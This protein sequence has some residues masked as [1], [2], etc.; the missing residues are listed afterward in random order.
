MPKNQRPLRILESDSNRK[1]DLFGRLVEDLFATFGYQSFR[2]NIHKSGREIDVEAQHR[3][4][5]RRLIAECK[6]TEAP[7][8]GDDLNKFFGAV[9]VE[10]RKL[11][12]GMQMSAYFVSLSGFSETAIEQEKEAG[13]RRFVR[14]DGAQVVEELSKGHI[15]VTEAKALELASRSVARTAPDLISEERCH[16]LAHELGWIWA[17]YF[18][19]NKQRTHFVLVHADGQILS[20]KLAAEVTRA[21]KSVGGE[22]GTLAYIKPE[23]V[24]AADDEKLKSA[25][26]KYL[27]YIE[28]ECGEIQLEGLPADQEVGSRRLRLENI[29]VPL[30]VTVVGPEALGPQQ[31]EKP[32]PAR[33]RRRRAAAPPASIAKRREPIGRILAKAQ[34]LAVLG[35]PGGGKSTLLKRLAIAYAFPER[36]KLIHDQL[37]E[38]DWLPLFIRCRQLENL[39]RSPITE[40][41][42]DVRKRAEIG[43]DLAD[44]FGALVTASLHSGGAL[45]LVDGLDEISDEGDRLA[46]VQQLRTF[47]AVYPTVAVVMTCREAGF[48]NIAGAMTGHCTHLRLA[49]FNNTDIRRLTVAWH[50]EVVGDTAQN[51]A[52]AGKLADTICSTDRVRRL[53]QNPLL[54]TALLLVK[55]WV[56][57]LPTKR[58]VLYGKAVEVLLMTWN[59]E[60]HDPIDIEEALPQLEFV[61]YAMMQEG[62]Q[63]VSFPRLRDILAS[64]RAQMPEL[65]AYTKVT[66]QEFIKRVELRSSLLVLTGYEVEHGSLQAMYEFR[67]LTFQEYLTARAIV[68]GH[69][70]G[71]Q[72]PDTMLEILKPHL[73]DENWEEVVLLSAVMAGRKVQPLVKYLI[74]QVQQPTLND[75]GSNERD[76]SPVNLLASCVVDEIQVPPDLLREALR[77]IARRN[78]YEG[79]PLRIFRGKYGNLFEDVCLHELQTSDS[80]LLS[81]GGTIGALAV[82]R[83]GWPSCEFGAILNGLGALLDDPSDLRRTEGLLATMQLAWEVQ[84]QANRRKDLSPELIQALPDLLPRITPF[85]RSHEQHL[86]LGAMWAFVWLVRAKKQ[87]GEAGLATLDDLLA[88]WAEWKLADLSYLAAWSISS[89]PVGERGSPHPSTPREELV[90]FVRSR[91]D[92]AHSD[93]AWPIHAELKAALWVAYHVRGPWPDEELA[94]LIAA[95]FDPGDGTRDQLLQGLGK[96]GLAALEELHRAER[97]RLVKTT[98]T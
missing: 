89:L 8:G 70:P 82:D 35:L 71:R 40:I 15:I 1:G 12:E 64:A 80:D 60:G 14:L 50:K 19:L 16:L 59:V 38:R 96:P 54:L 27:S 88:A 25:M 31:P 30:H 11:P 53:A 33:L 56:G 92:S 18:G 90:S 51:V 63:R 6:A 7:S 81:I 10:R 61:A 66:V 57:Q 52:D 58:S 74:G 23:A 48:R 43:S 68:N 28:K 41:L 36:R 46:F 9:D 97:D 32:E 62:S 86:A 2:F 49:D 21:D 95:A 5:H 69:Y 72:D 3:K 83:L 94:K 29:F 65:L 87:I 73:N 76:I 67:H 93:A 85:I 78:E 75:N 42:T 98:T 39:V 79:L 47:L 22:L 24:T 37:P 17:V 20:A 84:P 45:L 13:E 55:R 26:Q 91:V 77:W 4:E 44:S 34:R